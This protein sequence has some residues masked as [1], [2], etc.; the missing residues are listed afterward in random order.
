MR[1]GCGARPH[2]LAYRADD[3][4][5]L[6]G[7]DARALDAR[8]KIKQKHR[9][10]F[11]VQFLSPGWRLPGG[12]DAVLRRPHRRAPTNKAA[13]VSRATVASTKLGALARAARRLEG[14]LALPRSSGRAA[15]SAGRRPFP[16][17]V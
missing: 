17:R 6:L 14:T 9:T 4:A 5:D 16:L 13:G 8:K 12:Y 3:C 7:A 11:R 2:T 1:V 10:K 15:K